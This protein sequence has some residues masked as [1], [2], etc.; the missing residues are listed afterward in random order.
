MNWVMGVSVVINR[1]EGNIMRVKETGCFLRFVCS[2][3]RFY[4][5]E[6]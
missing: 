3:S 1:G 2:G 6:Q 5:G 4:S